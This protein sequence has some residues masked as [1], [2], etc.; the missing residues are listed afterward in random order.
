[1]G[2]IL[3]FLRQSVDVSRIIKQFQGILLAGYNMN[4]QHAVLDIIIIGL[5]I[6][7]LIFS[8]TR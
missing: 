4:F 1:M 6:K 7:I 5:T 2:N 8:K 3:F